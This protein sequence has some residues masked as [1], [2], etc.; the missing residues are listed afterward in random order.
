MNEPRVAF[1]T[2][3]CKVNQY[4]TAGVAETFRRAGYRVVPFRDEAEVYV[5]NTC[6]VTAGGE[7]SSRQAIRQA[8]RRNQAAVIA[9]VG[10]YVQRD[11]AGV[12]EIPG[13]RVLGGTA[14]K[15]EL[16]ELVRRALAGAD[17]VERILAL[18]E[19]FEEPGVPSRVGDRGLGRVRAVLK[20]QEGCDESCAYCIIP[21][22]RG[23]GRSRSPA[24]A[25]AEAKALAGS[26]VRELVVAGVH[27]GSFPGLGGLLTELQWVEG[28]ARIRLS[29]LEPFGIDAVLEAQASLAKVCPHLHLPLQSGSSRVLA[30]MRRPYT[31][32]EYAATVAR[33]RKLIPGLAVTTDC[34][35]GFPGE[36]ESDFQATRRLVED[37]KMTRL[38]VFSFSA[39][40]G[41][42]AATLP[43]RVPPAM[44]EE[45]RRELEETGR[46]LARAFAAGHIGRE[47]SV[48]VEEQRDGWWRGKTGDYLTLRFAG[49]P[50]E[51]LTNRLVRVL[52]TG[53]DKGR[54]VPDAPLG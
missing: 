28:I 41:T 35:V 43:D 12:R 16:M 45:R 15:T 19:E 22:T 50:G 27:L 1:H 36:S 51:D 6:A 14:G 46:R 52:V 33:A 20:V 54:L 11:P 42:S 17:R 39:R 34:L 5:I 18:P 38:H 49:P 37:L 8:S 30:R 2:L 10:C 9:V 47:V 25:L 53:E 29:S 3:G 26:G 40:P 44:V 13:V 24:A 23:R 32:E 4:D 31:A 21:A 48:L 7:K